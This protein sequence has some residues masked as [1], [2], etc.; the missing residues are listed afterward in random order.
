MA[1]ENKERKVPLQKC[2]ICDKE[3]DRFS[4]EEHFFTFH[5]SEATEEE[6]MKKQIHTIQEGHK[7]DIPNPK[8]ESCGKLFSA[9][10]KLKRHIYTVHEGHKDHKCESCGKSFSQAHNLKK[11][12][13]TIHKG[14]KDYKCESCSKSFFQAQALKKHTLSHRVHEG[15]KVK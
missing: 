12:I 6:S 8:C 3:F 2:Y 1:V 10:G 11:H 13:Q 7:D 4:L 9:A 5:N 15:H 14:H